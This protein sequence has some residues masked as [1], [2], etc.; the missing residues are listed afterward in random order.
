MQKTWKKNKHKLQYIFHLDQDFVPLA[1]LTFGAWLFS[2]VG[3]SPVH[4]WV[5]GSISGLCLLRCRWHPP[6]LQSGQL[7]C[8]Q[9]LPKVF[10]ERS[11]S[12]S[13]TIHLD[14][15]V[16]SI[17]SHLFYVYLSLPLPSFLPSFSL[18]LPFLPLFFPF[19]FF[20]WAVENKLQTWHFIP[21]YFSVDLLKTRTFLPHNTVPVFCPQ[22]GT[23]IP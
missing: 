11:H 19:F 3:G 7:K 8:P 17:L 22:K 13:R 14:W 20:G 15:T 6:T 21:K 12:Q 5:F 2:A 23:E 16:I 9:T 1:L 4:C 18:P 10:Q